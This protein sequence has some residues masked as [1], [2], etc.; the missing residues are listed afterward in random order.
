[1]GRTKLVG[2]SDQCFCQESYECLLSPDALWNP[3][4]D[5][6][7][8]LSGWSLQSTTASPFRTTLIAC[9]Q[10]HNMICEALRLQLF[11]SSNM[12]DICR[13]HRDEFTSS[14]QS[15]TMRS[16]A[17]LSSTQYMKVC[18]Y[19][20]LRDSVRYDLELCSVK[21]PTKHSVAGNIPTYYNTDRPTIGGALRRNFAWWLANEKVSQNS[22]PP[23]C[24]RGFDRDYAP[25]IWPGAGPN[26]RPCPEYCFL[27]PEPGVGDKLPRRG[28]VVRIAHASYTFPSVGEIR[29]ICAWTSI[30]PS[31]NRSVRFKLFRNATSVEAASS[32]GCRVN[33]DSKVSNKKAPQSR[34]T[35][36]SPKGSST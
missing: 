2:R 14:I 13:T 30:E 10:R 18:V 24:P 17:P 33:F 27:S 20:G 15:E 19:R 1:M 29:I 22:H 25:R 23:P 11:V 5:G 4:V 12:H 8:V 28:H 31:G 6:F 35:I 36:S 7:S 9:N 32:S 26:H 21:V 16:P 3:V 34:A